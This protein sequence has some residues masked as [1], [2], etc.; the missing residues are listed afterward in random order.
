MD[1]LEFELRFVE[2]KIKYNLGAVGAGSITSTELASNSVTTDKIAAGAVVTA[3]IADGAVTIDKITP[4][5][6]TLNTK[7]ISSDYTL[8]SNYNGVS[9]GPITIANGV[10]V[11]ISSGSAWSIV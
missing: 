7:T 9:A 11:T 6:I 1:S 8:S 4:S 10:T 3:D 5:F 2:N